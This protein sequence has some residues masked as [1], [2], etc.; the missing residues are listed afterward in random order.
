MR[1][2]TLLLLSFLLLSVGLIVEDAFVDVGEIMMR[3][4]FSSGGADSCRL[5]FIVLFCFYKR[6]SFTIS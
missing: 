2:S 5:R 1:L 4:V 6:A 3:G